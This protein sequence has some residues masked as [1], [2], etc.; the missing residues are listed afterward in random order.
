MVCSL[1]ALCGEGENGKDWLC[2]SLLAAP[3]AI[4]TADEAVVRGWDDQMREGPHSRPGAALLENRAHPRVSG[5]SYSPPLPTPLHSWQSP[6]KI[7]IF[8]DTTALPFLNLPGATAEELHPASI[9]SPAHRAARS[10]G[11]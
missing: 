11:S 9:L 3:A 10:L 8:V 4:L 2:L 5:I 6:S 1:T 7:L